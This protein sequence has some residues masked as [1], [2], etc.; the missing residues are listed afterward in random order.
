MTD[1]GTIRIVIVDDHPTFRIGMA[2]LLSEI[3]GFEVVGQAATQEDAGSGSSGWAATP[4]SSSDT[5]PM[6]S[7]QGS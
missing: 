4:G 3:D 7:S 2:A 6:T 5:S 1:V